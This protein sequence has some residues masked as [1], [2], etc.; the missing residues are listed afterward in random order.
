ML[1]TD[2]SK[3]IEF[4]EVEQLMMVIGDKLGV[5]AEE[6]MEQ[7]DAD[8]D[9]GIDPKELVRWFKKRGEKVEQLRKLREI[10]AEGIEGAVERY[11]KTKELLQSLTGNSGMAG[12]IT[13][14]Q[15]DAADLLAYK[16]KRG[17]KKASKD[18]LHALGLDDGDQFARLMDHNRNAANQALLDK[19]ARAKKSK[20]VK[21]LLDNIFDT[22]D[23]SYLLAK[24]RGDADADLLSKLARG[25]SKKSK[26]L[27]RKL[28]EDGAHYM[29]SNEDLGLLITLLVVDIFHL[30]DADG[31]KSLERPELQH[32][33]N[34]CGEK[35]RITVN[36]L[37]EQADSSG[38][39]EVSAKELTK[40]FKKRGT[41]LE[42]LREVQKLI[43]SAVKTM[44]SD[45]MKKKVK[46]TAEGIQKIF[47]DDSFLLDM[48]RR[49]GLDPETL[50][51]LANWLMENKKRTQALVEVARL[52]LGK[53]ERI[54]KDGTRPK[55]AMAIVEEHEMKASELASLIVSSGHDVLMTVEKHEA[56][57][58]AA[59]AIVK[60]KI[61]RASKT[62][63][64][65][66][67]LLR[68]ISGDHIV[69]KTAIK[70]HGSSGKIKKI[71][72]AIQ[73]QCREKQRACR[74]LLAHKIVLQK[75]ILKI[76]G[77]PNLRSGYCAKLLS[78]MEQYAKTAEDLTTIIDVN[79]AKLVSCLDAGNLGFHST[80]FK[81][82]S[83]EDEARW[84]A[85]SELYKV[86]KAD[87]FVLK[88]NGGELDRKI[89]A[90]Q[91]KV[92]AV[93]QLLVQITQDDEKLEETWNKLQEAGH[94]DPNEVQDLMKTLGFLPVKKDAVQRFLKSMSG[95]EMAHASLG[96]PA[97]LI[98]ILRARIQTTNDKNA[99]DL[100]RQMLGDEDLLGNLL[101]NA[102]NNSDDWLARKLRKGKQKRSSDLLK[103]LIGEDWLEGYLNKERLA[104]EEELRLK[105]LRKSKKT[106][107]NDV[108]KNPSAAL[109]AA[110]KDFLAHKAA[111]EH[112]K[113]SKK[114]RMLNELAGGGS[115]LL[116]DEEK[117]DDDDDLWDMDIDD[118]REDF[119]QDLE[120]L[121]DLADEG[122]KGYLR[123]EQLQMFLKEHLQRDVELRLVTDAARLMT[124]KPHDR[125]T[126]EFFLSVVQAVELLEKRARNAHWD[127]SFLDTGSKETLP[128]GCLEQRS[129][130]A[131]WAMNRIERAQPG[132]KSVAKSL[133]VNKRGRA[134]KIAWP[135]I[136]S[137]I[138]TSRPIVKRFY[139]E[140]DY[141]PD[142]S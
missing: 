54:Q 132:L 7:A 64:A 41:T 128:L 46:G 82:K 137:N 66:E 15:K 50:R 44:E 84:H 113:L 81:L 13:A 116:L 86:I 102:Q 49:L 97:E 60:S 45:K 63:E 40:W 99:S 56:L 71:L 10:I 31:S 53:Y 127:L 12:V 90:L 52:V 35:L 80:I 28:L 96:N 138:V 4:N 124:P 142:L 16:L 5:T 131:L 85:I 65:C 21:G 108:S 106:I 1:D 117:D 58:E 69:M 130:E 103:D 139:Y 72:L 95:E 121:F 101:K 43:S 47:E 78:R 88:D 83:D 111:M 8:G 119:I 74:L 79:V 3:Q 26:D 100:L 20:Q 57:D 27:M 98:A 37:L 18:L 136:Y 115:E 48:L 6:L 75:I 134:L 73:S 19:L 123:P 32:F 25:K 129:S 140:G 93:S 110:T 59:R 11:R 118:L 62:E 76:V 70:S 135:D 14:G 42:E 104:A 141:E 33:V 22:D 9:G 107:E 17:K 122:M 126:K 39:G 51:V 55:D 125:I 94:L 29:P 24:R 92:F 133:K 109:E 120:V 61:L 114:D 34:V 30:L 89:Q 112:R 23:M 87:T 67:D 77:T 2:G 38:D 68:Y 91:K 36:S 105:L